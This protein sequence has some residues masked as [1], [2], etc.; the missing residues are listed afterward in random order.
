M[1]VT[2]FALPLSEQG[3]SNPN[4]QQ[5]NRGAKD[6]QRGHGHSL[7]VGSVKTG[8]FARGRRL[9]RRVGGLGRRRV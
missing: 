2:Y 1:G 5:H 6:D 9:R 8:R 4:E 3:E 7:S